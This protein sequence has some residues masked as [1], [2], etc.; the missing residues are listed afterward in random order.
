MAPRPAATP[1]TRAVTPAIFWSDPS[2]KMTP[3]KAMM[4]RANFIEKED[5]EAGRTS[6]WASGWLSTR[7]FFLRAARKSSSGSWFFRSS[8]K[9]SSSFSR[10]QVATFILL[11]VQML[12]LPLYFVAV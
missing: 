2:P 1:T 12:N 5:F 10:I 8:S 11:L 3:R 4:A 7:Y 9:T 6:I